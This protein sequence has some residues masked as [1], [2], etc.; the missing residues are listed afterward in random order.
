MVSGIEV[1]SQGTD[2]AY[3]RIVLASMNR[4]GLSIHCFV[5]LCSIELNLHRA[6]LLPVKAICAQAMLCDVAMLLSPTTSV[7]Q[8]RTLAMSDG[9]DKKTKQSRM[10]E[11]LLRWVR[12]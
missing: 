6:V 3:R 1:R 7:R 10:M 2:W 11:L 8:M 12:V 5:A 4:D 9:R